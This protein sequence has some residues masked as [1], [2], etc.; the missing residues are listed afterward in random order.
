[1]R[2]AATARNV[3]PKNLIRRNFKMKRLAILCAA[4]VGLM[5][6][7]CNQPDT[8]DADVKAIQTGET[9]WNQDFA[10]KDADKIASHYANDAVLMV[11]GMAPT[12]GKDAIHAALTQMVADP[13]LSLTFHAT[14]VDVAK[15]GDLAYTQ[16]A[17]TMTV[18]DSQT[19]KVINDHGSYVTTWR[20]QAD[21]TW[22][23][24][25]DIVASE[26]PPP[27]PAPPA[28]HKAK[29]KPKPAPKAKSKK[30]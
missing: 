12:N 4:A 13:A 9:Q 29:T 24:V 17:Y 20:K 7:A 10:S 30:H 21:G 1:M 19:K 2:S 6:T 16:G 14:K 5:I 23:A 22:K 27:A 15:S 25:A 8:H 11:S 3:I 26:V 18:T 28:A